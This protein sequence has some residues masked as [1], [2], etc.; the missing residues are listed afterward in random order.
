MDLFFR[1]A[2]AVSTIIA[3]LAFT[4]SLISY[5][6]NSRSE[7]RRRIE[8]RQSYLQEKIWELEEML[9]SSELREA[10]R[11]VIE[12][13]DI[14][15]VAGAAYASVSYERKYL[16]LEIVRKAIAKGGASDSYQF[17]ES[18]S[19][20]I[21]ALF[22]AASIAP[23]DSE[24]KEIMEF[25]KQQSAGVYGSLL[26]LMIDIRTSRYLL[27]KA[28]GFVW[29]LGRSTI[30][31]DDKELR[32]TYSDENIQDKINYL[33]SRKDES[34]PDITLPTLDESKPVNLADFAK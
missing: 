7:K 30:D 17:V 33:N 21:M 20:I 27:Q 18:Y 32:T 11:C 13:A 12:S 31:V 5:V 28:G 10:R 8:A 23:K 34:I 14:I 15:E 22:R 16:R 1:H 29:P 2:P 26:E 4:L 9:L 6:R 24:G 19:I 25:W 3:F